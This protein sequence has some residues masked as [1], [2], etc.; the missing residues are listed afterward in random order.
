M[1]E[2]DRNTYYGSISKLTRVFNRA[3]MRDPAVAI[4]SLKNEKETA[5]DDNELDI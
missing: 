4:N 3:N 2:L 5:K 1:S